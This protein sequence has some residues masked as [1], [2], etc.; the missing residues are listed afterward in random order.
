MEINNILAQDRNKKWQDRIDRSFTICSDGTN[1]SFYLYAIVY[2]KC[3]LGFILVISYLNTQQS[4]NTRVY[5]RFLVGF[6]LLD[7]QF[8][9][10]VLQI[11]VCP[12]SFGHCVVCSSSIYGFWLPLWYLQT[13]LICPAG[14]TSLTDSQFS[15]VTL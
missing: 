8:Y 10:Y 6:V 2:G 12:F 7:L 13:L 9:A 14:A 4:K 3:T 5:L 15:N 1:Q 11:V